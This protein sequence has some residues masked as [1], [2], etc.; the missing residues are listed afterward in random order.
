MTKVI[1]SEDA[2]P[3][4]TKHRSSTLSQRAN[5]KVWNGN[6]PHHLSRWPSRHNQEQ[7]NNAHSFLGCTGADSR[8]LCG[9][10]FNSKECS[11][12]WNATGQTEASN[13]QHMLKITISRR[14]VVGWEYSP[15]LS[16]PHCWNSSV[17]EVQGFR[18]PSGQS[19]PHSFRL[20]PF[21]YTQDAVRVHRITTHQAV[22]DVVHARLT[23]QRETF[24]LWG[25]TEACPMLN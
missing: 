21:W 19:R 4:E 15:T 2:S 9:E 18:A 8:T 16:G 12:L 23:A 14:S 5:I 6:L 17:T 7:E 13:S 10:G 20:P 25:H 24:F 11:L 3:L 22:M 1:P